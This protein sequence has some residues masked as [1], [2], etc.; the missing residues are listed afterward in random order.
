MSTIPFK[1]LLPNQIEVRPTDTK[2]RG[3]CILLLYIN[4]RR[5]ASIL[6]DT[7]GA[8]NWRMEYKDVGGKTYG[9]LSI[10]D[11]AT[12][13]WVYKEDTGSESNIESD[14]GLSS[15]ILKRCL[16][17]WGCDF[18][19][20]AP[21]I[22]VN[23]PDSY[24]MKNGGQEKMTM[25]FRVAHIAY[26]GKQITELK[27]VD[28]FDNIV[29]DWKIDQPS[30]TNSGAPLSMV[31]TIQQKRDESVSNEDKLK[32]FC[33]SQRGNYNDEDLNKFYNFYMR[34]DKRVGKDNSKSVAANWNGE[35]NSD[36]L[37]QRWQNNSFSS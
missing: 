35:F 23:C 10:R 22:K 11:P 1:G 20:S 31:S 8:Y 30:A 32:A 36:V 27:I 17:R 4:S 24:Y 2:Q 16:A 19:Y 6:D 33:E 18:L 7:V 14:K 21:R 15:D 12:G 26:E 3:V 34:K 25:T 37:W 13:E 9:R 29:F 28:R 5:A